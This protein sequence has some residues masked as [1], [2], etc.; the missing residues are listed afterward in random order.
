[1][2][3]VFAKYVLKVIGSEAT[4]AIK[5]NQLCEGFKGGIDGAVHKVQ[6]ISEINSTK[7]NWFL[8]LVD[9]KNAFDKIN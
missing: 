2:D 6:Y 7:K 9:E 1:M 4:H 8:L 5:D 3:P